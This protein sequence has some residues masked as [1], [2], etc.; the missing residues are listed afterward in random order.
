V[1]LKKGGEGV[2]NGGGEGGKRVHEKG[3]PEVYYSE[4]E[5]KKESCKKR[6]KEEA[7][8][9]GTTTTTR[10]KIHPCAGPR[11]KVVR[12]K[13]AFLTGERT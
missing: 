1:T 11:A 10:G 12:G 13:K 2:H 9:K 7:E 6:G 5:S 3:L 4:V 8:E